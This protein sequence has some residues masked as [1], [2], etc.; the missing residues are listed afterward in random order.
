[1]RVT[2]AAIH[3][4]LSRNSFSKAI[5]RKH[6]FYCMFHNIFWP[7]L[8]QVPEGFET[9]STGIEGVM[10]QLL[11]FLALSCHHDLLGIDHD[12]EV[13]NVEIRRELRLVFSAKYAGN[14]RSNP[15]KRFS[16]GINDIPLLSHFFWFEESR[17]R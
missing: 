5:V 17:L 2:L 15:P 8:D 7:T 1:M 9:R 14:L 13:P 6:S 4:Q 16:G 3:F 12:H 10:I 11:E